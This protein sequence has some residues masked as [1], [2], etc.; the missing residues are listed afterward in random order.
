MGEL[1]MNKLL[2]LNQYIT[3]HCNTCLDKALAA[4]RYPLWKKSCDVIDDITFSRHGLLRCISSAHSGRH[5][6]QITD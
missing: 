2:T 4:E 1:T 5:Y 6:L 3:E